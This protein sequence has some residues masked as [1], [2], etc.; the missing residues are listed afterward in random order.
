VGKI[1]GPRGLMPTPKLG[2]VTFQLAE[3]IKD[4]KAGKVEFKNDAGGVIH[5][6]VG[7]VSFSLEQLIENVRAFV[8]EVI[9]CKPTTVRGRYLKNISI[10]ATMSPGIKV[11][12]ESISG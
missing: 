4:I 3:V 2:T 6:G 9:K 12:L 5:A 10:C 11:S 7:K 8:S 1:L